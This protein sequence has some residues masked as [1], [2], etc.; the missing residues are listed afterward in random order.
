MPNKY[1]VITTINPPTEA[2]RQFAAMRDWRLI[3]VGDTKTPRDW[4]YPDVIYLS[5]EYQQ[6]M[7]S[8]L[9][10]R[11]PWKTYSRKMAGYIFALQSGA[12][13][14]AETDDDNI[15]YAKWDSH[16]VDDFS[17]TVEHPGFVNI[18]RYFS[19]EHVWPRGFPLTDI[20]NGVLPV[21]QAAKP[22]TAEVGVWQFLAD[23]DP[24]VDAI[25]RL[26]VNKPVYFKPRAK[27]DLAPGAICPFNSQ[28]TF[29]RKETFPL[30]YLPVHVTFRFT[31]ILRGLVAQP[32][33]W[34]AG[35]TLCFGQATVI[36]KR[37]PHDY[38][39]DFESEIPC[40]LH[41]KR[42]VEAVQSVVKQSNGI[43]DNL[44]AAYE[45][46]LRINIVKAEE[47]RL[48][49]DWLVHFQS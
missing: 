25:Y 6:Q 35:Y 19:A 23:E 30:M 16:L 22:R 13:F 9:V 24:D 17:E 4:Q 5:P 20:V 11:L 27:I 31:D 8:D 21:V 1:I 10:A 43:P 14:I 42:I 7:K 28:N 48:L 46:L 29:F 12:E 15:P 34:A 37:N 41:P 3:V 40:Y 36:Q 47:I 45:A 26:T 44:H 33:L 32:I 39:A 49:E 38:L 18:Y 2:V